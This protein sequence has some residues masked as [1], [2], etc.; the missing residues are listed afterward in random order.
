MYWPVI[1][2]HWLTGGLQA[3]FVV[4][5]DKPRESFHRF[6]LDFSLCI[7]YETL[8]LNAIVLSLF[9]NRT[10]RQQDKRITTQLQKA[11]TLQSFL[12]WCALQIHTVLKSKTLVISRWNKSN[13]NKAD[14]GSSLILHEKSFSIKHA[15][16][17]GT[18]NIIEKSLVD[19][20]D[21]L[22]YWSR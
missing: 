22:S 8:A 21:P 3:S 16:F 17:T 2:I 7:A 9:F 20:I 18:F 10:T 11:I 15:I 1:N 5:K 19:F 6:S 12:S 4:F 14:D 13:S